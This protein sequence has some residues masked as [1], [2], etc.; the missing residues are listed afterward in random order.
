[1]NS[2]RGDPVEI[3]L[4]RLDRRFESA[5]IVDPPRIRKLALSVQADGQR[6]AI[7]VVESAD[8][9]VLIDGYRRVQ[10]LG[11]L[12]R[13][14]ALARI[15]QSSLSDAVL[16]VIREHQARPFQPI[17]EAWL[18][19]GLVDEGLSQQ[20]I[21]TALGK[22]KSWVSR[23]LALVSAL[24]E[25]FQDAVRSGEITS[26]AANRVL[27]PLAR[28]NEADAEALL[29]A[30]RQEPLSTRALS[31]WFEHYQQANGVQR[32][33]MLEQPHLFLKAL[34][35]E[36][37]KSKDKRLDDGPEGQW[38][39]DVQALQRLIK[40]LAKQLPK[41]FEPTP[42]PLCMQ[43]LRVAFDQ[44]ARAFEKLRQRL[45]QHH[46]NP[47]KEASPAR[48]PSPGRPSARDQP[49]SESIAQHGA[50]STAGRD[51]PTATQ[52]N[53]EVAERSLAA[54]RAALEGPGQCGAHPGTGGRRARG[55]DPLQ[56]P[57][58]SAA[59]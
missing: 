22:D 53:R 13:D 11:Q 17:E 58:A 26:W 47:R 39:A 46:A 43:Q 5:R 38:L 51:K 14:R 28:A 30:I 57:D 20:A 24:P 32:E 54:A 55:A 41:V 45:E 33:R 59:S 25:S 52:A 56:H 42:T 6:E 8:R 18:L 49:T 9:L 27:L 34:N 3:D 7:L 48:A 29:A 16:Q 40:R 21:A 44:A 12:G 36:Q 37:A 10:A 1:M 50:P 4:H 19:A 15:E 35:E 2:H 31:T 23:R